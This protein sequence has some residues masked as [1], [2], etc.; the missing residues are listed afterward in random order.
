MSMQA[1]LAVS[2]PGSACGARTAHGG[3]EQAALQQVLADA[4]VGQLGD[5]AVLVLQQHIR[6]LQVHVHQLPATSSTP[7]NPPWSQGSSRMPA[8]CFISTHFYHKLFHTRKVP[9]AADPAQLT[10]QWPVANMGKVL[11]TATCKSYLP[12]TRMHPVRAALARP[13]AMRCRIVRQRRASLSVHMIMV[14]KL[15]Y[16]NNTNIAL[17][18]TLMR[19]GGVG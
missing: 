12:H 9:F 7:Q 13:H 6:A 1:P 16:H 3:V 19:Q 8:C 17:Q 10:L 4:Q 18:G 15:D 5:Q 11:A 14:S 2:Q